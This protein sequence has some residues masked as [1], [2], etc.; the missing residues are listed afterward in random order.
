MN[1]PTF[2]RD[3]A[4]ELGINPPEPISEY[5]KVFQHNILALWKMRR[6]LREG[7]EQIRISH[8]ERILSGR[9]RKLRA[10]DSLVRVFAPIQY[11][12]CSTLHSIKKKKTSHAPTKA[13]FR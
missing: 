13:E 4:G 6:R 5:K 3:T 12:A 9:V 10:Q 8:R 1:W 11:S 2:L 7:R